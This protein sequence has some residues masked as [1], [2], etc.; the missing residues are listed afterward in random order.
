V[1]GPPCRRSPSVG[2]GR[3]DGREL[4]PAT[5]ANW[6]F[7]LGHLQPVLGEHEPVSFLPLRGAVLGLLNTGIGASAELFSFRSRRGHVGVVIPYLAPLNF[8]ARRIPIVPVLSPNVCRGTVVGQCRAM[9]TSPCGSVKGDFIVTGSGH[10]AHEVQEPAGGCKT[11][12]PGSPINEIGSGR[13]TPGA[14]ETMSARHNRCLRAR[15]NAQ[16]ES[17]EGAR[18]ARS[19]SPRS[20][21]TAFSGLR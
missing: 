5:S 2:S 21:W 11:H 18:V 16:S 4:G 10:R 9:T 12:H 6:K 20:C 19:S 7:V 17:G 15:K 3:L 8:N 1:R 14:Q 13:Q